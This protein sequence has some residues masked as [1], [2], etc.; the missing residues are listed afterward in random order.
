MCFEVTDRCL[1][2]R[3][4]CSVGVGIRIFFVFIVFFLI[5]GIIGTKFDLVGIKGNFL[6]ILA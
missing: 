2:L 5:E 1:A 3:F 6:K 4:C